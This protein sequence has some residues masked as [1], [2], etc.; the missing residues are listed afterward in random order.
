MRTG[1]T[2]LTP[3]SAEKNPAGEES[4]TPPQLAGPGAPVH[5]VRSWASQETVLIRK[6]ATK[7]HCS[8][9][10]R[11]IGADS[12]RGTVAIRCQGLA[13]RLLPS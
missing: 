1:S 12:R 10:A 8:L 4:H 3:G 11:M 7:G 5:T 9:E 2:E 6:K 13:A